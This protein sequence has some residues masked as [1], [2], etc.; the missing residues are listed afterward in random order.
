MTILENKTIQDA[1]ALI[2]K[3][4]GINVK[5]STLLYVRSTI[6]TVKPKNITANMLYSLCTMNGKT[7][8]IN[9]NKR[10]CISCN[11]LI[12][13][14]ICNDFKKPGYAIE[15][16]CNECYYHDIYRGGKS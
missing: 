4:Y 7:S 15:D 6:T 2:L 16:Y 11:N 14:Y 9:L 10:V 8:L 12:T 3:E 5:E 1:Q 13:E